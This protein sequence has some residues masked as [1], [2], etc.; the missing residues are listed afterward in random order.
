MKRL[1]DDLKY[2]LKN[3]IYLSVVSLVALFSYGFAMTH[4]SIGVDD[5]CIGLYFE[6]G[7][8]PAMGR[9]V[10]YLLNKV[11]SLGSFLPWMTEVVAVCLLVLS[12]TLWCVLFRRVIKQEIPIWGYTI[13]AGLFISCPLISEVYVYYLHNGICLSYGIVALTIMA[14]VDAI[15][16]WKE[17]Q[18]SRGILRLLT[19]V[20]LLTVALGCYESFMIVSVIGMLMVFFLTRMQGE[21]NRKEKRRQLGRRL[22]AGTTTLVS[23]LLLRTI[24][25]KVLQ[26]I[27]GFAIPE[28]YTVTVRSIFESLGENVADIPMLLKKFWVMY[29]L[30]AFCYLPI[31]VL[32]IGILVL[33]IFGVVKCIQKKDVWMLL[34]MGAIPLAPIS[35]LF[36]EWFPTHYRA[37]QYVPLIGAFAALLISVEITKINHEKWKKPI[38]FVALFF[39]IALLWNQ[40][41]DMNRWFYIDYLKYENSKDVMRQIAYDLEKEHDITKPII[42]K[43]K[44]LVPYEI[45]QDAYLSVDSKEFRVMKKITD[46]FDEHLLEK[47]YAENGRGYVFAQSPVDSTLWWGSMAFDRTARELQAFWKMHGYSFVIEKDLDTIQAAYELLDQIPGYPKE[48][49]IYETEDNIIINLSNY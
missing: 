46:V 22:L 1:W 47:F 31:T 13:F 11:I 38:S 15:E 12:V 3:K 41:V 43:G 10:I 24:V 33:L 26:L 39:A 20:G 18:I 28:N 49:Y 37:S 42:V 21:E 44:Y 34:A 6:E 45:S 27:Y 17:G 23:A 5:T 19:A 25:L 48:G 40:A 30:N 9:W 7:I 36:I 16:N 4:P 29:Y 2:F 35:M 32:V 14:I 8:A